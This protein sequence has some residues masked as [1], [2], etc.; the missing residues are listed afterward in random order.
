MKKL[1]I[2]VVF[3]LCSFATLA[4]S[5]DR[6]K[7]AQTGMK[8]LSVPTDARMSALGDAATATE[9]NSSAMFFNTAGMARIENF[10]HA[11]VGRV[12]WIADINYL[13]GSVALNPADGR[14]GVFGISILSVDYGDIQ[15][16]IRADN[17]DG[18]IDT[19][20]FSPSAYA[21][22]LGYAKALSDK[23]SV[24]GNVKYVKQELGTGILDIS[25]TGDFVTQGFSENVLAFD[26]GILYRTGFRSLNFGMT[27]KN[28]SQEV[29]FVDERFQLPLTFKIG[30]AM[31]MVDLTSWNRDVHSL[32]LA[33]DASHPRDFPEQLSV[34]SEYIFMESFALRA[35]YSFP[36]DEHG[37]SA[38]AGFQQKLSNLDFGIDYAYTPFGVFDAVHRFTFQFSF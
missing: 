15:G 4:H 13:Y 31:D 30:I 10:A 22:G 21:I 16:T 6:Q 27:V 38:G 8:F 25:S 11:S 9:W 23:F 32:K 28:F 7:L 5:Q 36:N 3:S 12:Q 19:N 35:G 2:L 37:F 34:G 1:K 24:G 33:V 17:N 26:F 29:T 14:Y 20:L 18:Y